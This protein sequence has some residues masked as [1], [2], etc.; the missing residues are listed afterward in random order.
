MEIEFVV[1][2]VRKLLERKQPWNPV[3]GVSKWFGRT[4]LRGYSQTV[5]PNYPELHRKLGLKEGE[6]VLFVA[7]SF[8]DWANNLAETGVEVHY[9]DVSK[10]M[11]DYVKMRFPKTRIKSFAVAD[12]M[13]WPQKVGYDRIVS[14][15]PPPWVIKSLPLAILRGIAHTKGCTF[16]AGYERGPKIVFDLYGKIFARLYGTPYE[17][18]VEKVSARPSVLPGIRVRRQSPVWVFHIRA[19]QSEDS[20][21]A[22]Q[23]DLRILA[24]LKGMEKTDIRVLAGRLRMSENRVIDSLVR[25]TKL[26]SFLDDETR[27]PLVVEMP[28]KL[29]RR[30]SEYQETL[31]RPLLEKPI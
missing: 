1:P 17:H 7:G 18:S 22:A 12:S 13:R 3:Q 30:A 27:R 23:A 14:F 11:V 2:S 16:A 6:R 20:R 28:G 8:G 31:E 26:S 9:T 4:Y 25:L 21:K 5:T 19:P 10:R 15:D 24:S 29:Y